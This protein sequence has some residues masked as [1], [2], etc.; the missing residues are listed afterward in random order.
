MIFVGGRRLSP[1]LTG[2]VPVS[3]FQNRFDADFEYASQSPGRWEHFT[4]G[5][6]SIAH[7]PQRGG[8][9]MSVGANDGDLAIR[10]SRIYHRYQPGKTMVM[11]TMMI[12]GAPV[13]NNYQRVGMFDDGNGAF[14]E[15]GNPTALNPFGMYLVVRSDVSGLPFDQRFPLN[16]WSG[17]GNDPAAL[18]NLLA[19]VDWTRQQMLGLS[20]TWYGGGS[21]CFYMMIGGSVVPVHLYQHGNNRNPSLNPGPWC[22]TGNLPSRYELRNIGA[23]GGSS[24]AEHFGVAVGI[25]GGNDDQRGFTYYA[26]RQGST[27]FSSVAANATR[28]PVLSVRGRP[29]GQITETNTSTS[30]T[31]AALARLGA[32]WTINAFRGMYLLTT[33]G[34]GAGQIARITGNSATSL[35]LV[36]NVTGGTLGTTLGSGTGYIIGYPN[37]GQLLPRRLNATASADCRLEFIMNPTLMGA[38]WESLSGLGSTSSFAQ[39]DITAT[40]L[41]GGEI[42]YGLTMKAGVPI[43]DLPIELFFPLANNIR[44][45]TTDILTVAATTVSAN[46]ISVE[47][48]HQEAMS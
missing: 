38:N 19:G 37:R 36:D 14:W 48:N 26:G 23:A 17:L 3:L 45:N 1:E 12:F 13:T 15:Q 46:S 43:V 27:L 10:Q 2:R 31:T 16:Q 6:A 11:N 35:S 33:S 40:A 20:Y 30:G 4:S 41:S 34:P 7:Q 22:R 32:G 29:M 18:Q 9:L 44:G 47:I 21:V 5:T 8:V 28:V 25:D 24:T 39:R 42:I